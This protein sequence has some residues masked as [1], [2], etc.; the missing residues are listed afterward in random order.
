MI[1]IMMFITT[2]TIIPELP[3]P[4][5]ASQAPWVRKIGKPSNR[6]NFVMTS[7]YERASVQAQG[8]LDITSRLPI[9][10]AKECHLSFAGIFFL[11]K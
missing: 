4:K 9:R 7:A 11:E 1:C 6:E 3:R 8:R 5:R 10:E 2:S